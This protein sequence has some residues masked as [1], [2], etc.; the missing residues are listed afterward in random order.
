M[1]IDEMNFVS[2]NG[3]FAFCLPNH[4][5]KSIKDEC[6][7]SGN[8]ETGGILL[9]HYSVDQKKAIVTYVSGPTLDSKRFS[10]KFFRGIIGL[11][12]LMDNAWRK[13]DYYIGEWH[14]HP[15]SSSLPS[16][17]D[18]SQMIKL[19]KDKK[20]KCPEPILL[21]IG[22]NEKQRCLSVKV[23]KNN[24]VIDLYITKEI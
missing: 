23:I 19:S 10:S 15:N 7:K 18:I 16:N 17:T 22:G 4:L 2:D 21:I 6:T 1:K 12:R 24:A 13:G 8:C 20:L 11:Q 5:Y 9:G 3:F 14:Y